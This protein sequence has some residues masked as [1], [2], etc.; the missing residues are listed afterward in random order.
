MIINETVAIV[1]FVATVAIVFP[2]YALICI[3]WF[4]KHFSKKGK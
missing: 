3:L 2:T 4:V 1:A